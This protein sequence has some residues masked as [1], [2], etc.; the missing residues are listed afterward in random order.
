MVTEKLRPLGQKWI[1]DLAASY[2][3]AAD[4]D[5]LLPI[6][7]RIINAARQENEDQRRRSI[8]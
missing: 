5:S 6:V 3:A 2:L 4:K 8:N 1:D 7:T